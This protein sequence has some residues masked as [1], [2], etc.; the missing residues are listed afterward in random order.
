MKF[1]VLLREGA[2]NARGALVT[3]IL[4]A[5]VLGVMCAASLVT[6]GRQAATE[7]EL[8]RQLTG[9]Q[10]RQLTLI[11]QNNA[12]LLPEAFL[13]T[14]HGTSGVAGV[15]GY[16]S[17]VDVVNGPLGPA[18]QLFALVETGGDISK[19]ITLTAG[20][21]PGPGEA[22][23]PEAM[24]PQLRLAFPSGYVESRGG[25]QW[26]VVGS[27][28]PGGGFEDLDNYLL[29]GGGS[30]AYVRVTA[31]A[32]DVENI[33]AVTD[34][35]LAAIGDFDPTKLIIRSSVSQ[36]KQGVAVTG[37]VAGMGRALLILIL[38]VGALFIAA[39]VL[40]DVLIR[41]RDLGRRR[42][43]GITRGG[44]VALVIARIAYPAVGG[45]ALG[46]AAAW[47]YCRLSGNPVALDFS[48]AVGVLAVLVALL[49]CIPPAIF[50]AYRDPVEVMRTP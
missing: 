4:V 1:A 48:V 9:P 32:N 49:A 22:I 42:T 38:G 29:A 41:R 25:R 35:A 31:L 18:S 17:T 40:A 36:A 50:A 33:G 43:L 14:L 24:L 47:A 20:R 15:V 28:T 30:G 45:T 13:E 37:Q 12:G 10:A 5:L 23:V 6:V 7:A 26:A 11:D 46:I 34:V 27:F 21:Y 39:V 19:I 2:K 8:H 16:R 3:T 44:L